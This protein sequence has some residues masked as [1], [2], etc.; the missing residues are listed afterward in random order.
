MEEESNRA[1]TLEASPENR[2]IVRL[3]KKAAVNKITTT[4]E[5]LVSF[6]MRGILPINQNPRPN[7]ISYPLSFSLCLCLTLSPL[8]LCHIMQN[9]TLGHLT[10]STHEIC[11]APPAH[12]FNAI[13]IHQPLS[14]SSVLFLFSL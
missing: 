10:P 4:I 1:R 7:A 11:I 13:T 9:G 12:S 2:G 6:S 5:N 14:I 8:L 3:P